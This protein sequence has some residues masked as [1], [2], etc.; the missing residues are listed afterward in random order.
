MDA[1]VRSMLGRTKFMRTLG[2]RQTIDSASV[3][4]PAARRVILKNHQLSMSFLEGI[5]LEW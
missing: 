2:S 5:L 1:P 4:V 3:T